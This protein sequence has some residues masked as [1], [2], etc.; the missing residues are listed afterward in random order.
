MFNFW[1][2]VSRYPR[3]FISA[4]AG[5]FLI[6]LSPFQKLLRTSLGKFLFIL[7]VLTVFT[8]GFLIFNAMLNL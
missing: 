8:L 6:L 3:F 4:T 7:I 2:N 1:E 5:L